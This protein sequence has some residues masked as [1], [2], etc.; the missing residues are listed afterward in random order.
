MRPFHRHDFEFLSA[1]HQEMILRNTFTG[2][3]V[4]GGP[5]T[6]VTWKCSC[7]K[8]KQRQFDGHLPREAFTNG[9]K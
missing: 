3:K 7:G 2:V 1:P 5:I 8:L 6:S 4:G 9:G